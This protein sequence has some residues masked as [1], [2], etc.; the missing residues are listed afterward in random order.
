MPLTTFAEHATFPIPMVLPPAWFN[1]GTIPAA[2]SLLGMTLVKHWKGRRLAGRIVEVEAYHGPNDLASHASKGMTDRTKVM[3]GPPGVLYVY[4]IYGMHWCLNIVTGPDGF[5]SAILIR[6]LEPLEGLPFMAQLRGTQDLAHLCSGPS[7]LC[8]ALAIDRHMNGRCLG[9][10]TG[11]WVEGPGRSHA[12]PVPASRTDGS[13]STR[14][15]QGRPH[16]TSRGDTP[17]TGTRGAAE[18]IAATARIG[19][20]YAGPYKKKPWRFTF[21]N[22]P[23]VSQ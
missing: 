3:F 15:P 10:A 1:Q 13:I 14:G 12:R 6:A 21:K 19:V 20:D 5:P 7:R 23:F 16:G 8:Q 4:L 22:N 17:S 9:S 2:R 18:E 11:L